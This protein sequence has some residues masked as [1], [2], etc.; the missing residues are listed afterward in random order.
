MV[1][2]WAI[3]SLAGGVYMNSSMVFAT[4]ALTAPVS[5][6]ESDSIYVRSTNGFADS[7]IL[8]M[9]NEQIGYATKT[10][11]TFNR[12]SV[13]GLTV[14]TQ[15]M[16]RGA[17][18][19]TAAAHAIGAVVRTPESNM[20]NQAINYKIAVLSDSSGVMAFVTV[21]LT[22]ISLLVSFFVLPIAF[23]GSDLQVLTYIWGALVLGIIVSLWISLA[24]GRKAS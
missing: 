8:Q 17:N 15:P 22:L 7:G 2:L 20:M 14:P 18:G 21:S 13:I 9:D 5:V 19:T 3:V 6:T 16:V 23:L 24:G 1:F 12:L 10:A 4:S 11:N